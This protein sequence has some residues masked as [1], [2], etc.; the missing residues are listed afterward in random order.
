QRN[1]AFAANP[2]LMRPGDRVTFTRIDDDELIRLREQVY[3]GSYRYQ[4]EEGV[5]N[6]GEYIAR[7][8]A[9]KPES[10]AFRSRQQAAAERTPVP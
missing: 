9:I 5:L 2:I 10:D 7:L 1:A 6:V 8:A 4:I 3:D